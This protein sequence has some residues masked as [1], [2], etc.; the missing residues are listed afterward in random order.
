[1][2][3]QVSTVQSL[4]VMSMFVNC[5]PPPSVANVMAEIASLVDL[6]CAGHSGDLGNG[7][8]DIDFRVDRYSLCCC[9]GFFPNRHFD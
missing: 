4:S 3:A 8:A 6:Q 1:M 9:F 5:Q 2:S 7:L